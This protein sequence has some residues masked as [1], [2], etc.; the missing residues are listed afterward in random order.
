MPFFSKVK[1]QI[2]NILTLCEPSEPQEL[3]IV[4]DSPNNF[5]SLLVWITLTHYRAHLQT[6]AVVTIPLRA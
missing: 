6:S 4:R 2:A 1:S 3:Q 5:G